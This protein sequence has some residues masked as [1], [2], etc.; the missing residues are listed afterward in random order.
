MTKQ[1]LCSTGLFWAFILLWKG[2]RVRKWIQ[3]RHPCSAA[4]RK[5]TFASSYNA[6]VLCWPSTFPLPVR[7]LKKSLSAL[8]SCPGCCQRSESSGTGSLLACVCLASSSICVLLPGGTAFSACVH[9]AQHLTGS[10]RGEIIWSSCILGLTRGSTV[11]A[12]KADT[13]KQ[14]Q[15]LGSYLSELLGRQFS[16]HLIHI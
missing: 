6:K 7:K 11:T 9:R 14:P 16:S 13:S 3:A 5:L 4:V 2:G 8:P 15:R 10:S 1:G 12:A